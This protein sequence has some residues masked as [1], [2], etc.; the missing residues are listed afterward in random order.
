V[1]I[2]DREGNYKRQFGS[3]GKE[4]GSQFQFPYAVASD[5]HGNLLVL[6]ET[7]WLLQ[8]FSPEQAPLYA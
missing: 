4:V 1:Q 6:D 8:V 5:V 2:F 7:N 3:L